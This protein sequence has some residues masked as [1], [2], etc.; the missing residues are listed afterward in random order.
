MYK[1]ANVKDFGAVG[2]GHTDDTEAIKAA[3]D[4]VQFEPWCGV[5]TLIFPDGT[6][7]T[8]E[9]IYA[10][11]DL[12]KFPDLS[13]RCRHDPEAVDRT[14]MN[15]ASRIC[16]RGSGRAMLKYTGS[17][18]DDYLVYCSGPGRGFNL[19]DGLVL[20]CQYK[21]RG[22]FAGYLAYESAIRNLEIRKSQGIALDLLDCWGS[23]VSSVLCLG[24][25]GVGIRAYNFNS[26]TLRNCQFKGSDRPSNSWPAADEDLVRSMTGAIVQV[27]PERRAALIVKGSSS[28]FENLS[29]EGM[30]YQAGPAAIYGAT[31]LSDWGPLRFEGNTLPS[32][33]IRLPRYTRQNNYSGILSV[34]KTQ[35]ETLFEC[36]GDVAGNTFSRIGGHGNLGTVFRQDGDFFGNTIRAVGFVQNTPFGNIGTLPNTVDGVQTGEVQ[37]DS[38]ATEATVPLTSGYYGIRGGPSRIRRSDGTPNSR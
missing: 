38:N 6:Y 19:V 9:S 22:L 14:P 21:C 23:E 13:L 11:Y 34:D 10:G 33:K 15:K 26:A 24:F 17:P 12:D 4:S 2:D 18:T 27:T 16:V 20:D 36:G 8:K 30:E 28:R 35:T 37:V 25:L 31:V 5:G 7:C 1:V 29:F 32:A 3:R